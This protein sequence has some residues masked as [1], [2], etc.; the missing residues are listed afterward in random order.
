M[1]KVVFI[2]DAIILGYDIHWI[3]FIVGK[4][5]LYLLHGVM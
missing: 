3:T 2:V 1:S 5:I 4:Y